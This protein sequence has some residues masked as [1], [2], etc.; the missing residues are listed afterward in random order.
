ML[1]HQRGGSNAMQSCMKKLEALV[2]NE[3]KKRDLNEKEVVS[4][5]MK[6]VSMLWKPTSKRSFW[7]PPLVVWATACAREPLHQFTKRSWRYHH[8]LV[9]HHQEDRRTGCQSIVG[10]DR[11]LSS[12][13]GTTSHQKILVVLQ[14]G[15]IAILGLSNAKVMAT[16]ITHNWKSHVGLESVDP[17]LLTKLHR[18]LNV[19][20]FR[21]VL[22][23]CCCFNE[24]LTLHQRS[25][26]SFVISC[27]ISSFLSLEVF[28]ISVLNTLEKASSSFSIILMLTAFSFSFLIFVGMTRLVDAEGAST[29][30]VMGTSISTSW[31]LLHRPSPPQSVWLKPCPASPSQRKRER[32][33]SKELRAWEQSFATVSRLNGK[34]LMWSSLFLK[35]NYDTIRSSWNFVSFTTVRQCKCRQTLRSKRLQR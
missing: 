13:R 8:S 26:I 27:T 29:S 16:L 6:T 3:A 19:V 12:N 18:Q 23:L 10:F 2:S 32:L 31:A 5:V 17:S 11:W 25:L 14:Q 7:K 21:H 20:S 33:W 22:L 15:V 4:K 30:T 34:K 28:F 1:I 24:K 9:V 35:T